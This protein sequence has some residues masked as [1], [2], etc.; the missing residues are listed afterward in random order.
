MIESTMRFSERTL[1][2]PRN[3]TWPV[4]GAF[5]VAL[6]CASVRAQGAPGEGL[7]RLLADDLTRQDAIAKI[8]ASPDSSLPLLLAWV[9]KPPTDVSDFGLRIGLAEAF[10]QLKRSE[11]IPF[12]IENISLQ[13]GLESPNTWMKT[14]EVIELRIPAIAAL[15][16]IGP[17]ACKEVIKSWDTL[18]SL[19]DRLAA[20]IVV[21]RIASTNKGCPDARVFLSNVLTEASQLRFRAE[22]G[23]AL[24]DSSR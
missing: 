22:K 2:R 8:A 6:S 10:G 3:L 21:S 13:R 17:E 1:R 20:L 16:R 24:L 19:E 12:L 7:A 11:G 4:I 23:L 14:A 18:G 9:R 15:I 5:A